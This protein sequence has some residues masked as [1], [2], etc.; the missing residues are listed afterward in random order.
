VPAPSAWDLETDVLV[1][2]SGAA[3]L[4]AAVTAAAGGARTL[5]VE[6]SELYGGTSATS[7]GVIWIPATAQALAAG[8]PD[9]PEEAFQYIR[10]LTDA[11]VSDARIW[12]FARGGREMVAWLEAH[13]A[14]HLRAH[15]YADYHPEMPGG[16]GGWRSLEA[17]PLH[18]SDLGADFARLR[19]PHPAVQFL[20]RVSWTLQETGA[21]L[22][23]SPGWGLTALTIFGNYFLDLPHRLHSA[24]DR[25]MTLGNALLGR[26]KLSLNQ[27]GGEL[28]FNAP[29]RGLIRDAGRILGARVE[30]DGR[31]L[32]VRA[33]RAVVLA[34]G[35]FERNA[36]MRRRFLPQSPEPRWSGSQLNNVGEA[37]LAAQEIGA[38][39]IAMDSA[40]W[41]T[42][43]SLPG[44]ERARL[45]AIE[46]ALPG[47]II[48]NSQGERYMN[49]AA[50]YHVAGQ[51]MLRHDAPL[52]RTIPSLM[53]F[54]GTWR[55]SYPL[56][57][58]IPDLPD[59]LQP[60]NL[61]SVLIRA[62]TWEELAARTA[63]PPQKLKATIERFNAHARQGTDP[64]FRRGESAY[65]RYYGDPRVSPN[66]TL[67]ALET[68]PFYALPVYPG[69][70]GTN[71]GLSTNEYAQVLDE[72]GDPIPGLYA[73]GN[74]AATVMGHSYP[75]AGATLGPGMTFGF[76]A[77]RHALN[78]SD[79]P[80][81][82]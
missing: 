63:L 42:S 68:P 82:R 46:R 81:S 27:A 40:W 62:R 11:A 71:G 32:T 75:A 59:W 30:R 39:S 3:A 20:G 79:P 60:K 47:S 78:L 45:M 21:L 6:K 41:G 67:R 18:A 53:L 65:D 50:S 7:G 19:P 38:A 22:F 77:A 51:Q 29:L 54:D 33:R 69:D 24:R 74:T 1:A 28:W 12:A 80:T 2:G 25:R 4:T 8:H 31:T 17:L 48:V 14:V 70:I 23:R 49:E 26:L 44:E 56:G 37:L 15:P 73:C 52:A 36:E 16:K 55:R 34:A 72:A 13:T 66:P 9:S 76:I 61:R 64:D 57:P 35:G 5:V 10:A 43:M 58:M